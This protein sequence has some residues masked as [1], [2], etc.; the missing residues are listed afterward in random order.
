MVTCKALVASEG[1]GAGGLRMHM[2]AVG[3]GHGVMQF[4]PRRT[5]DVFALQDFSFD[6]TG[7]EQSAVADFFR[8]PLLYRHPGSP[9]KANAVLDS[10]RRRCGDVSNMRRWHPNR[11]PVHPLHCLW[12]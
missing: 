2:H 7:A 8:K 3:T 1:P 6:T 10:Q 5:L 9:D 11:P 4:D 12:V